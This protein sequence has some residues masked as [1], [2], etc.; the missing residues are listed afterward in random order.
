MPLASRYKN[1]YN[2]DDFECPAIQYILIQAVPQRGIV[3]FDYGKEV[4]R[5]F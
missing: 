5:L 2:H 4:V 3:A 1:R